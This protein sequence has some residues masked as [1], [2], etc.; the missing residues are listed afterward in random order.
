M[1]KGEKSFW[2]PYF[3][4]INISDLPMFWEEA[5]IEE[6]QDLV[7]KRD[8]AE[9]KKEYEEEWKLMYSTF[10]DNN[11]EEYFPGITDPEAEE[12]LKNVF[13]KAFV[14]VVT[15]CFGWGLPK[16]MVIPFAD[17]INHHNVDSTY[18]LLHQKFHQAYMNPGY[19]M[20]RGPPA[21][22]TKSKLE[23]DYSDLEPELTPNT[24]TTTAS[25]QQRKWPNRTLN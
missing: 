16:T 17:C 19:S 5:D 20:N 10:R 25:S 2:F 7:L 22:Y 14:S 12:A 18:E 8:V 9:Y 1:L 13:I 15:R 4:I 11:Y 21:Y 24:A 23:M 3:Q 6:L